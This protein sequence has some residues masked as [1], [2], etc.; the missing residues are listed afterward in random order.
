MVAIPT[1]MCGDEIHILQRS[2]K[3]QCIWGFFLFVYWSVSIFVFPNIV[4]NF[5][6]SS[7]KDIF[8]VGGQ[9]CIV[10]DYGHLKVL[11]YKISG[12]VDS[13]FYMST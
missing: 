12:T 10:P 6:L 2:C 1:N 13:L 5:F 3:D 8:L 7:N 4:H 11:D 9:N